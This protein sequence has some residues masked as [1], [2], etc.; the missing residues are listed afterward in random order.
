MTRGRSGQPSIDPFLA[1]QINLGFRPHTPRPVAARAVS[2]APQYY[3]PRNGRGSLGRPLR[4]DG[5]P[6]LRR[7]RKNTNSLGV[8]QTLF[9]APHN[10]E[11]LH[12]RFTETESKGAVMTS[13]N[14]IMMEI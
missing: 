13:K 8:N 6:R 11:W 10:H 14:P 4:L 5:E 9:Y 3:R 12:H 7:E 1:F 2:F